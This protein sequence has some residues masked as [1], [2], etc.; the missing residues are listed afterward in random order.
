MRGSRRFLHVGCDVEVSEEQEEVRR[1][2]QVQVSVLVLWS[3]SHIHQ[4]GGAQ[5]W[6]CC[7][8]WNQQVLRL[9]PE[10]HQDMSRGRGQSHQDLDSEGSLALTS[11]V[12]LSFTGPKEVNVE[13]PIPAQLDPSL[14][15]SSSPLGP[16]GD[17]QGTTRGSV[18]QVHWPLPR[19]VAPPPSFNNHGGPV[20]PL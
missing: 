7:T 17:H 8:S 9:G 3:P 19:P 4:E 10:L 15:L 16:P 20:P 13:G 6:I 12:H 1:L 11:G 18:L 14:L 2:L 5:L